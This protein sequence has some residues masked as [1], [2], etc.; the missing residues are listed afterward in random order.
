MALSMLV[1]SIGV[2]SAQGTSSTHVDCQDARSPAVPRSL[3]TNTPLSQS[4]SC[5]SLAAVDPL[6]LEE[7]ITIGV[8]APTPRKQ[9]G[10][11]TASITSAELLAAGSPVIDLSLMGKV[12]GVMIQQRSG[13]L[14]GGTIVRLRGRSA[15]LSDREPIYVLDGVAINNDAPDLLE[16]GGY[17]ENRLVDLHPADVDRVEVL[18]GPAATALYGSRGA[19]GV[20][21][22][23]SRRGEI[24][25]PRVT[26]SLRQG[27]Q[28]SQNRLPINE[29]P[30]DADGNSVT[31]YDHQNLF[32]R[33]ANLT[34][35]YASIAGGFAATKYALSG[36]VLSDPGTIRGS[37]F[38]RTTARF[39][40]Q[41]SVTS[42]LDISAG[43]HAAKTHHDLLPTRSL[44]QR[45]LLGPNTYAGTRDPATGE[46]SQFE[47]FRSPAAV[48]DL[49]RYDQDS[50][51]LIGDTRV[52]L[53]PRADIEVE[54][55]YGF[56]RYDQNASA[57]IPNSADL[58]SYYSQ[59]TTREFRQS[60]HEIALR[61]R[62]VSGDVSLASLV[63]A[64]QQE[65]RIEG[66]AKYYYDADIP[67]ALNSLQLSRK[68]RSLFTQQVVG[69]KDRLY[70]RG[71]VRLEEL[72]DA[73]DNTKPTIQ[74]A[75]AASYGISQLPWWRRSGMNRLLSTMNVRASWGRSAGITSLGV[76]EANFA[77]LLTS[78]GPIVDAIV[79]K[80]QR[81]IEVGTDF[82]T[83]AGRLAFDITW[84]RRNTGLPIARPYGQYGS[85]LDT[86][87]LNDRGLEVTMHATPIKRGRL[88]WV[89]TLT[90]ASNRS[91]IS[92]LNSNPSSIG[93]GITGH[94]RMDDGA[95]FG[96]FWGAPQATDAQGRKL[97][98]DGTPFTDPRTQIPLFEGFAPV[99][100]PNPKFI[101]SWGNELTFGTNLKIRSQ[102]DAV[103]GQD[104][105]ND[106]QYLGIA[107]IACPVKLCEQE[108]RGELAAGTL[109]VLRRDWS[110]GYFVEDGSF[111]KLRELSAAY[112]IRP[113]KLGVAELQ[114]EL[115]GR[116]LFSIDNYTGYDPE[117]NTGGFQFTELP[118]T[119][120]FAVG[121]TARF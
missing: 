108:L 101:A 37:D 71:A 109:G 51:R 40:L 17:G 50:K 87:D 68:V 5:D 114:I 115:T 49:H 21:Q 34:D 77:Q 28:Q 89:T 75:V 9:L 55:V 78:Q 82:A 73:P 44:S 36:S 116:N 94:V 22:I 6:K 74:S 72:E 54:Y 39:G 120:T 2:A 31:R 100:N 81:E 97:A 47:F 8:S 93:Y 38:T 90:Y 63:G 1:L 64:A 69:L 70:L 16:V 110:A 42:R 12:A 67:G 111:I 103:Q 112:T 96:M 84:Y 60:N 53:R 11:S 32:L 119:R 20:I 107:S 61:Y 105:W 23:F 46:Y 104:I 83:L 15:F 65:E 26:L 10:S 76:V 45:F 95:A 91:Q 48:V 4:I 27:S 102:F 88:Q 7:L 98:T 99:G 35:G 106:T 58:S 92:G 24:G 29:Y 19:N 79:A 118:M 3:R 117:I 41:Q 18:R 33:N 13:Q 121:F 86:I 66:E 62:G 43:V 113:R 30:F 52:L 56:D 59:K 85:T 14:S 80:R 25:P 57:L